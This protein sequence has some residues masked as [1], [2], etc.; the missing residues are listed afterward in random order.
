MENNP[1]SDSADL[2]KS[3]YYR[4]KRLFTQAGRDMGE[5]KESVYRQETVK[6]ISSPEQLNDYLH[7]TNPGI[8]VI[9]TA[10]IA[11]MIGVFVWSCT[12]ALETKS[13]ASMIVK[14]HVAEIVVRDGSVLKKGM[15]I[16]EA[17]QEVYIDSVK[18]DEYG[19][20]IGIAE[21]S[22]PDGKYDAEVVT[23]TTR[24]VEFLLKASE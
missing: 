23:D 21:V 20:K 3:T 19:R 5:N 16:R 17:S 4:L 6:R 7:V 24:P 11:F 9:L 14:D 10:V 18:E 8:W 13:P 12:G 1:L 22:L 2:I 15:L